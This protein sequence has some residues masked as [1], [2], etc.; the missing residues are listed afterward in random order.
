MQQSN[1]GCA[2]KSRP[3]IRVVQPDR[4]FLIDQD[5]ALRE[6]VFISSS[7]LCC[8]FKKALMHGSWA[9]CVTRMFAAFAIL[10]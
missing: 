6:R 1:H 3:R 8:A 9:Y 10:A 4:P 7:A 2:A 5:C